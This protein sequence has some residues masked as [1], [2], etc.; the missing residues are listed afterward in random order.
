MRYSLA[1][2]VMVLAALLVAA[3]VA[4]AQTKFVRGTVASVGPDTVTVTVAGKEMTFKV[5]KDTELTARGAGTAQRKA[6][7][8]GAAGVKFVDFVKPGTGVEIHY[9]DVG[10][11]LT[12]T[13]I[14][15]GLAPSEATTA[16]AAPGGSVRGTVTAISG[17]SITV[18]DGAK[19]WVFAVDAKTRVV[20]Q[21]LGTLNEKLKAEGKAPTVLDLVGVNDRVYVYYKEGANPSASEIRMILKAVK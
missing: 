1:V 14:H 7:M 12:A 2:V 13:D 19:D 16:A 20:G 3:P 18:K 8:T 10:G 9:K 5:T 6:E 11:V 17:T 4:S 21:G 15:S